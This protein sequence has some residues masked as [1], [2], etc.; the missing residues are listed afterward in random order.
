MDYPP[1]LHSGVEHERRGCEKDIPKT[2]H[3]RAANNE[4]ADDD[5]DSQRAEQRSRGITDKAE[6]KEK[7]DFM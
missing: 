5:D 6:R 2:Q 3:E 7:K 1:P 4:I